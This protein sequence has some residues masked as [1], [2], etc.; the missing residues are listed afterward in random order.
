MKNQNKKSRVLS[1][2]YLGFD[3]IRV[4]AVP[5]LLF[6]R[7]K[8][9][10]LTEKAKEKSKGGVLYISNHISL[11]D[12]MYIMLSIWYRRHHFVAMS[13]LFKGKFKRWLFTKIFLCIE[14]N[15]ENFSIS[16]LNE[17]AN[18]LKAGEAVTMFPEGHI[19]VADKGT[20]AF[21]SG[22]I[23]MALKS[24]C[25]IVPVYLK[26]RKHWHSRLVVAFGEPM[27]VK[28]FQEG[29]VATSQE[30]KEATEYLQVQENK[31]EELCESYP[32]K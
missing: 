20:N 30:I 12:P 24:G 26:R 3:F 31:L 1:F 19:N 9:L 10:F 29:K 5:G 32:F 6:F 4:S 8:K 27:D 25:P 21:K 17:I 18:H 15:R 14:I 22:M 2:K 28:A 7:P 11:F 16:S 23:I 13:Q